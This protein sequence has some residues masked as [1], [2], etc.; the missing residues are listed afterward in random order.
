MP[1]FRKGLLKR[2]IYSEDPKDSRNE[3][4]SKNESLEDSEDLIRGDLDDVNDATD[5]EHE[6]DPNNAGSDNEIEKVLFGDDAD[7]TL[8]DE[9]DLEDSDQSSEKQFYNL[10]GSETEAVRG[11]QRH[12]PA[13]RRPLPAHAE[14]YRPPPEYLL[15]AREMKEWN[16]LSETPWLRKYTFLPTQHHNLRSVAAYSRYTRERFLR[17]LDLYLAPR[18]IK[19]RLTISPSDLVPQL[20]SPRDLRPFPTREALQFRGHAGPVRALQPDPSGQYLVTGSDDGT[21]KGRY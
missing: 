8:G 13:P 11:I 18:A 19:M 17:C 6:E 16:K 20:P 4:L 12:I 21:L 2:K 15:D 10:W 9:A 1:P 5:S 14:S 3:A 7:S